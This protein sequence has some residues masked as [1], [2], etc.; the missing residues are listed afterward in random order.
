MKP[1]RQKGPAV[2]LV[3]LQRFEFFFYLDFFCLFFIA[4][5]ELSH[6]R[7]CSEDKGTIILTP[8]SS[9]RTSKHLLTTT[10]RSDLH[11]NEF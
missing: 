5:G 1:G 4:D 3:A 7:S 2:I 11:L 10:S 9:W 6:I 8:A